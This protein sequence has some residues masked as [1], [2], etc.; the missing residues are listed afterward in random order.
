MENG[1]SLSNFLYYFLNKAFQINYLLENN[2]KMCSLGQCALEIHLPP[3]M[4][5]ENIIVLLLT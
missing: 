1:S 3:S 4:N 5:I 2:I